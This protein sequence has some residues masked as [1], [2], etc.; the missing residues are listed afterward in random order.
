M[1]RDYLHSFIFLKELIVLGDQLD[2]SR[3]PGD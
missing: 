1:I 3:D 2:V